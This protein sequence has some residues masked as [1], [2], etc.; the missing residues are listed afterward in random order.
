MKLGITGGS[1]IYSIKSLKIIE[2]LDVWTPFGKPSSPLSRG[3]INGNEVIFLARHGEGHH[4]PP[5]MLNYRANIWAMKSLGVTHLVAVSAVGSLREDYAPGDFV[6]VDQFIDW[7][8]RRSSTFFDEIACHVSFADPVCPELAS[9]VIKC[10]E[11]AGVRVHKKGT[12]V[13]IDGPEFSSRAESE[14]FRS[15]K[16]DVIGMT[17]VTEARLAREAELH[18]STLA[19]VTDYDCWRLEEEVVSVDS[20]LQII[21]LNAQKAND[22]VTHI[23]AGF[24]DEEF[25]CQSCLAALNGALMTDPGL[26][27]HHERK[28]FDLLL[29]RI[30]K[31]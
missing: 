12:Y 21:K 18:F 1:G 10:A 16:A 14:L 6:V 9:Y 15:M 23:A 7:T 19:M 28:R 5:H 31:D 20:V 2:K 3:T 8:K 22:T 17:N 25:N 4:T 13:C 11:N 27:S 24:A 26:I 29:K 30:L